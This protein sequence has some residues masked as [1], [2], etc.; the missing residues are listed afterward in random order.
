MPAESNYGIYANESWLLQR[1]INNPIL[2]NNFAN[3]MKIE[4]ISYFPMTQY[5]AEQLMWYTESTF[6]IISPNPF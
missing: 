1:A 6:Q 3:D 4:D 2:R 5:E